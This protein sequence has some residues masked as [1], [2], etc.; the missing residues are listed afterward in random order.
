MPVFNTAS[1]T[2]V[3]ATKIQGDLDFGPLAVE[4]YHLAKLL[5]YSQQHSIRKQVLTHWKDFFEEGTDYEIV[6]DEETLRRYEAQHRSA[7]G[8]IR[9][10]KASRGRMFLFPSGLR[11]VF[12]RTSK[13][14][15]ELEE[16]LEP[17][18]RKEAEAGQAPAPATGQGDEEGAGTGMEPSERK[19]QYEI[20]E[21]LLDHLRHV[22]E[23]GLRRLA[24]TSAELG[25]GRELHDIRAFLDLERTKKQGSD[26]LEGRTLENGAMVSF[27]AATVH[28]EAPDIDQATREYLAR[29]P[30]TQGP[31]FDDIPNV[32]YGLKQIGEKAGGYSAV[33]AGRAADIVA[34][35]LGYSHD[36][37]RKKKLPFNELPELP[38][39]TSGKLRKMYRFNSRFANHVIVTLRTSSEF[40]PGKPQDLSPFGNGGADFPKLS[41]GPFDE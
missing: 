31:L 15:A 14:S 30:I 24:L 19:R 4:A 2:S 21:R 11:K 16:A 20:L 12:G 17:V 23:P 5:G 7:V 33:Q 22:K 34:G 29:R 38:D 26:A 18:I 9:P 28:P 27:A 32:Y 37:I 39:T 25:L 1:D 10:T 6:H 3:L 13:E 41:R 40:K 35:R 36:D 8:P